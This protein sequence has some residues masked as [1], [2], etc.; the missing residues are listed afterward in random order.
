[1]K[2]AIVGVAFVLYAIGVWFSYQQN[3]MEAVM[4]GLATAVLL[5]G[6]A[7][8]GFQGEL[9]DYWMFILV[10]FGFA[11]VGDI[12]LVLQKHL[13]A[14]QG[15]FFIIGLGAFLV[16]YLFYGITFNAVGTMFD[17]KVFMFAAMIL[18]ISIT[19][20]FVLNVPAEMSVPIIAYLAQA[21]ILII[22]AV[23]IV[24]APGL[25]IGTKIFTVIG[26]V[27]LYISDS[28][29]G[30]NLYGELAGKNWAEIAIM[31]IYAI[32]QGAI[33]LSLFK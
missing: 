17:P 27:M 10:G 23:A 25:P 14:G 24:A 28:F 3:V 16:G 29:I 31:G 9:N 21:A 5:G 22:G 30:H 7:F 11:L 6:V 33:F 18:A 13:P 4:K 12:F 15:T 19:Q 2:F 8:F 1:M 20:Y 32:G 26:A